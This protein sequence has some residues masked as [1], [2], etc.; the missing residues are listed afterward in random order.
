MAPQYC[1]KK[2]KQWILIDDSGKK[3]LKKVPKWPDFVEPSVQGKMEKMAKFWSFFWEKCRYTSVNMILTRFQMTNQG[4]NG[5][6]N[7][8][9]QIL[10]TQK[11]S[12]QSKMKKL[13]KIAN[14]W[15][16]LRYKSGRLMSCVEYLDQKNNGFIS[17]QV[18][19]RIWVCKFENCEVFVP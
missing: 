8:N 18:T 7:Q 4:K 9:C 14:F 16:L 2:A 15:S 3:K 19:T 12:V 6:K 1:Q 13:A 11:P 10:W 5:K 17:H